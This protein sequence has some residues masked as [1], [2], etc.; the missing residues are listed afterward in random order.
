MSYF[1][2]KAVT[3]GTLSGIRKV[4]IEVIRGVIHFFKE[5]SLFVHALGSGLDA[6]VLLSSSEENLFNE[7]QK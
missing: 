4:R 3:L 2:C 1:L 7:R 5:D 6:I